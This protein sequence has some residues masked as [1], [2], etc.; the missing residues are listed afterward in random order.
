MEMEIT[1]TTLHMFIISMEIYNFPAAVEINICLTIVGAHHQ[2]SGLSILGPYNPSGTQRTTSNYKETSSM[3]LLPKRPI[4]CSSSSSLL[5]TC[6]KSKAS[7]LSH[8]LPYILL[9]RHPTTASSASFSPLLSL[10]PAME[11]ASMHLA[12]T[13]VAHIL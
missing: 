7:T 1:S 12:A 2:T 9:Q 3:L 8:L 11:S 5:T 13:T 10:C 4:S 6:L